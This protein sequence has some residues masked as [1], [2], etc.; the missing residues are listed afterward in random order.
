MPNSGFFIYRLFKLSSN[1]TGGG[2][3][4]SGNCDNCLTSNQDAVITAVYNFTQTIIGNTTSANKLFVPRTI[5]LSGA[6]SGSVQFD[7]AQNVTINTTLQNNVVNTNNLNNQSVTTGK[8]ADFAI[9]TQKLADNSVTFAKL[10][11]DVIQYLND[12]TDLIANYQPPDNSITDAKI[13]P[14]TIDTSISI[15]TTDTDLLTNLLSKLAKQIK[16]ITGESDWKTIPSVS[17]SQVSAFYTK[18]N[19]NETITGSWT[20]SQPINGNLSGNSSTTDKLK[21]PVT[22]GTTGDV[23]G[24][25]SFDG[26][27]NVFI[28]TSIDDGKVTT[29]KIA[30]NA[31]T[32]NKI[33]ASNTPSNS[34]FLRGDGTWIN[35][36][37][38]ITHIQTSASTTWI[39][40]HGLGYKPQ[41]S[42]YTLWW[43]EVE[44]DIIHTNDNQTQ[45]IFS[46]PSTGIARLI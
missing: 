28:T 4:G 35:P 45:I 18:K 46:T 11:S 24:S 38:G 42:V 2:G 30:D 44:A 41:V 43:Q 33:S 40:N 1:N 5:A 15:G 12:L 9:I 3:G 10:G 34:T 17:L 21:T 39:I 23:I 20:F 22:I 16:L 29:N 19:S 36:T 27:G 37:I 31:V 8:I 32:I 7:G 6:V 14:R 13:G 26:S 25:A